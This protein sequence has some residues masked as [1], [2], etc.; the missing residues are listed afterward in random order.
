MGLAGTGASQGGTLGL[1][2]QLTKSFESLALFRRDGT[3]E[4]H[5]SRTLEVSLFLP[6]L[7]GSTWLWLCR[8]GL[9]ARLHRIRHLFLA[10]HLPPEEKGRRLDDFCCAIRPMGVLCQSEDLSETETQGR[11]A[12]L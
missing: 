1:I 3:F 11:L 9:P 6:A 8:D 4:H 5:A 7:A 2:K 12:A 10:G